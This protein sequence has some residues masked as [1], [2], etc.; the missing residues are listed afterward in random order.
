MER[1]FNAGRGW[2]GARKVWHAL[3]GEGHDIACYTVERSMRA[4]GLQGVVRGPKVVTI[5]TRPPAQPL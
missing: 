1:V 3:G 4:M 2:W 5:D